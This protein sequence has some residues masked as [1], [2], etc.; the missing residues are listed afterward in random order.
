M[1]DSYKCSVFVHS[2]AQLVCTLIDNTIDIYY[3]VC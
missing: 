1:N 3:T 2:Y